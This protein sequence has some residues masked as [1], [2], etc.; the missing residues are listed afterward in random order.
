MESWKLSNGYT[1]FKICNKRSNVYL[2]GC[3]EGKLLIDTGRKEFRKI[4]DKRMNDCQLPDENIDYLLL[5][6]THYDHCSNAKLFKDWKNLKI[7]TSEKEL[8][9]IS[10]GFTPVSS[11]TTFLSKLLVFMSKPISTK[12]FT[13]EA[14]NVDIP[15]SNYMDMRNM[16]YDV[17]IIA[18][19]GHSAGSMS[20]IVNKEI[21]LVGDALFGIFK[22]SVLPPFADSIPEL[23]QSWKKLLDSGC[24]IFLPGHGKEIS[25]ILLEKEYLKYAKKF[26]IMST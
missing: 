11:G 8:D 12:P 9:F 22:N 16:G 21:A 10:K 3:K 24:H 4:F 14:F 15:L 1:I 26:N 19:P 20:I 25:R 7:L 23:I 2:I 5:T 6:H 17:E 13:Y 18:T